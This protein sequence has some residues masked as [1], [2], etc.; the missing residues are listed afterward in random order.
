MILN[1]QLDQQLS[2]KANDQ[3][4]D[5][6]FL[7]AELSMGISADNPAFVNLCEATANQLAEFT[8]IKSVLDYGAG[9]G[10]Y[11]NAL[12]GKGY[13]VKVFEIFEAHRQYIKSVYPHIQIID[14]PVTTDCLLWIEVSEHMTDKELDKL[15]KTIQPKYIYH[16]STSVTTDHDQKWGHINIKPQ[17]DWVKLF[18][19][20]G[21]QLIKSVDIPT[22]WSK[23]YKKHE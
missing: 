11:A 21:Y 3:I 7:A 15:F 18:E 4:S 8:D 14:K 13:E 12:H 5:K 19:R 10:V 9:T 16:S 20:K 22:G 23:I 2:D 1:Q 17:D 6:E